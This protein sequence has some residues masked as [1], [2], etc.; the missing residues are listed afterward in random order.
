M[1]VAAVPSASATPPRQVK[2][3]AIH[4]SSHNATR[5][6]E[7]AGRGDEENGGQRGQSDDQALRHEATLPG[8]INQ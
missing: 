5:P 3:E 6:Q 7:R 2:R 4:R 1:I 8:G